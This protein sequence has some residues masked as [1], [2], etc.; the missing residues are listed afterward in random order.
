MYLTCAQFGSNDTKQHGC[1]CTFMPCRQRG[2]MPRLISA[3]NNKSPLRRRSLFNQAC[4]CELVKMLSHALANDTL[5][6]AI[7]IT[8]YWFYLIGGEVTVDVS[9]PD[10]AGTCAR[11]E[12]RG[13]TCNWLHVS[14]PLCMTQRLT[15]TNCKCVFL[16]H[17]SANDTHC[18]VLVEKLHA[19]IL[20]MFP[21]IHPGT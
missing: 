1:F 21:F 19:R 10:G 11:W 18:L 14:S 7:T 2:H 16:M 3:R 9:P 17:N 4:A 6:A 12:K 8:F 20:V 5:R 15:I 13:E